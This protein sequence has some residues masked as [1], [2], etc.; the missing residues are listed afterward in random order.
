MKI[1]YLKHTLLCTSLLLISGCGGLSTTANG[2]GNKISNNNASKMIV[3]N[4]ENPMSIN[5][6]ESYIDPGATTLGTTEDIV[7]GGDKVDSNTV[8]TYTVTYEMNDSSGNPDIATR[9]VIVDSNEKQVSNTTIVAKSTNT[10]SSLKAIKNLLQEAKNGTKKVFLSIAGDS[11]RDDAVAQEEIFYS[12]WLK[13]V[14]V[15]Y[16]HSAITSIESNDWMKDN[17][18]LSRLVNLSN[19]ISP[20]GNNSIIGIALGTNDINHESVKNRDPQH[21]YDFTL[22]RLT[23]LINTIKN[24]LPNAHLYLTEPALVSQP[25]LKLVYQQLSSK[26]DIP[27]V[28]SV[29]DDRMSNSKSR[30]WFKDDIHPLY[31]GSLRTMMHDFETIMPKESIE[32]LRAYTK[33]NIFNSIPKDKRDV[34]LAESISINTYSY[35][36]DTIHSSGKSV[37][38]PVIGGSI[39]KLMSDES[40]LLNYHKVLGANG[41]GILNNG[42][43]FARSN[44]SF[45]TLGT[46][47]KFI[48]VP[49]GAT[50]I[51]FN[52]KINASTEE[53]DANP[54][55]IRYVTK[56]EMKNHPNM[57]EIVKGL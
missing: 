21:L 30:R 1:N 5:A 28:N 32:A 29:L 51:C 18:G 35:M 11:K 20:N 38:V 10:S 19:R 27:L 23:K 6:G 17:K 54:I 47:Y 49:K 15:T 26:F 45:G 36:F 4:G 24:K 56:E 34:N 46:A 43:D 57:N 53:I 2:N 39:I 52:Y 7:I 37:T 22:N 42:D 25:K 33:Q 12:M 50:S 48:Y 41:K 31:S 14:G 16:G 13:Q 44:V 9:T 3:L 40:I 55:D 8:G